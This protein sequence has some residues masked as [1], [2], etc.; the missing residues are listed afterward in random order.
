MLFD[1][2]AE[3]QRCCTIDDGH[4]PLEVSL[5]RVEK[6]KLGSVC[7]ERSCEHLGDQGCTMGD[8][9]PFACSLYPL[10]FD[11]VRRQFLYDTDCPLMPTY[12]KQ[13]QQPDPDQLHVHE[14]LGRHTRWRDVQR[15]IQQPGP[16]R[17]HVLEQLGRIG[18]GD[19]QPE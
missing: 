11:P 15:R 19:V 16:D 4:L 13:L 9:K 6:K 10:S 1:H 12:V 3:C 2:C 7:I 8:D 17:L 14:Q 18:R 5:T